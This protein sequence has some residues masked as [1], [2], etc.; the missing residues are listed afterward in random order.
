MKKK[1]KGKNRI[2][3][4][5]KIC[6]TYKLESSSKQSKVN[7]SALEGAKA[8]LTGLDMSKMIGPVNLQ[9]KVNSSVLEGAKASLT[10]LDM[11]KMIGPVNLQSK[12]NSSV[13]E[14]A[15]ASL[16]GL[17]MSKMIGP[18][19]LQS[20]VNSSVLEGAKASL[21]GLS[22]NWILS[23]SVINQMALNN[24]E[25]ESRYIFSKISKKDYQLDQSFNDVDQELEFVLKNKEN[26][27]SI[28][29]RDISQV[30]AVTDILKSISS[31]DVLS[32]YR[33]L[34]EYPMLGLEH[35]VG[36]Q[37][38]NE[39]N[40][41][42]IVVKELNLFRARSRE[43]ELPFTDIEM[44]T[45][46]HGLSR[47]GRYNVSG[48]GELYTCDIKAVALSEI[49]S[50]NSNLKYDII[51]WKLQQPVKILDLSDSDSPL[52][53]YCSFEHSTQNGQ[54]YIFPNF[55]AQCARYHGVYGI[56]YKS[57]ENPEALNYVFFDYEQRW[58][59]TIDFEIGISHS[60]KV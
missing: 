13:L 47:Q 18:V 51:E 41:N 39:I 34:V 2:V 50:D 17:D 46:P 53:Q 35:S 20:K 16:T 36:R 15:K 21:T 19:N 52:V 59:K 60:L 23:G 55:L 24:K 1:K 9:S 28:P 6:S 57:V 40:M 26:N 30:L 4:T 33:H 25:R 56:V 32:L 58:F 49:T 3:D 38:F 11:S 8:S 10:G 43:R 31:K 29:V 45:A 42:L 5:S 37:I 14:G 44:F 7:S 27:N 48:Q 54:E 12:V 22:S